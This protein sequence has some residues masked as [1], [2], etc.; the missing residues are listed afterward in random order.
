MN[1]HLNN[2][3]S[4]FSANHGTNKKRL[5]CGSSPRRF[6]TIGTSELLKRANYSVRRSKSQ[7]ELM[8]C[9]RLRDPVPKSRCVRRELCPRGISDRPEGSRGSGDNHGPSR[10]R[11]GRSSRTAHTTPYVGRIKAG[12]RLA[13]DTGQGGYLELKSV[14]FAPRPSLTGE[15]RNSGKRTYGRSS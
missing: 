2:V 6:R 15:G 9:P 10:P 7:P 14:S 12:E 11:S 1:K 3:H 4:S 13:P 5:V 8:C